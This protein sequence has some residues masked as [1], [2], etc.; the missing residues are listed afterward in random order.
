MFETLKAL[1]IGVESQITAEEAEVA[2]RLAQEAKDK[3]MWIILLVVF[4][5]AELIF[6]SVFP[7]CLKKYKEKKAKEA[8]EKARRKAIQSKRK[9]KT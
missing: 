6:A 5:A 4:L 2:A 7:K 3:T 8:E 9:F 1:A